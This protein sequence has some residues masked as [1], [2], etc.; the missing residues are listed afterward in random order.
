MTTVTAKEL[1]INLSAIL[2]RAM[3]G[4]QIEVIYRSR[5][6]I[7]ISASPRA[8]SPYRGDKVAKGLAELVKDLPDGISPWFRDPK[9]NYKQIRDELYRRDLKY[10]KY[11]SR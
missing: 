6:A 1:R 5:P 2:K 11:F 9:R 4:E 8:N 7:Y 10:R 3:A